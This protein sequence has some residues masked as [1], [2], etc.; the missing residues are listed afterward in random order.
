MKKITTRSLYFTLL[1]SVVA[2]LLLGQS[3]PVAA[4]NAPEHE[5]QFAWFRSLTGSQDTS[6]IF[7]VDEDNGSLIEAKVGQA[8]TVMFNYPRVS[9]TEEARWN[10]SDAKKNAWSYNENSDQWDGW[11]HW[12][13]QISLLEEHTEMKGTIPF[14]LVRESYPDNN[15]NR[16]TDDDFDICHPF[17]ALQTQNYYPR[18]AHYDSFVAKLPG[19]TQVTFEC[20]HKNPKD[21]KENVIKTVVLTFHITK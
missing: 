8:I 21:G 15:M 18:D 11:T 6:Q 2:I 13:K 19:T 5:N 16:M 14:H 20:K 1:S 10:G 4:Q 17:G 7:C 3:S 12:A 9:T